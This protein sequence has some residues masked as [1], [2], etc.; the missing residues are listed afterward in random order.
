LNPG[1]SN[2][3]FDNGESCEFAGHTWTPVTYE[4]EVRI[5][6]GEANHGDLDGD[7]VAGEDWYNGYDDDGDG[8]IDED[9]FIADGIDNDNDGDIDE[10]ID[11]YTDLTIDGVDNDHNGTIDDIYEPSWGEKIDDNILVKYGRRD[12][13]IGGVINPF[14]VPNLTWQGHGWDV[15]GDY[16]YDEE[17]DS[18]FFDV[19]IYDFGDD[20]LPGDPFIDMAGDGELQ[21][22]ECLSSFGGFIPDCD[23]G[24]DGIPDTN[25]SGEGDGIWHS[26]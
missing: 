5:G 12:S 7:G 14:Y 24:L 3:N 9:Y 11:L 17:L 26:I 13:L 19:Y 10:N 4:E 2:D 18:L 15:M 22:G 1:C 16:K 6:D 8:L 20:G 25:D 23:Y 21:I